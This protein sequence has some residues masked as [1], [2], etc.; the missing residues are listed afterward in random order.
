MKL[1]KLPKHIYQALRASELM[2]QMN[3]HAQVLPNYKKSFLQLSFSLQKLIH[4]T[5][6]PY[7]YPRAPSICRVQ[8]V[9]L[10]W[11]YLLWRE[12]ALR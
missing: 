4:A 7:E 2:K 3:A 12:H 5:P 8:K 9:W 10:F 1:I 6:R 11:L